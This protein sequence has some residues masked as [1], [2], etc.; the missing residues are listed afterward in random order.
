MEKKVGL[1]IRENINLDV[2]SQGERMLRDIGFL[3]SK[4]NI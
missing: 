4:T 2:T 1:Q 3:Y